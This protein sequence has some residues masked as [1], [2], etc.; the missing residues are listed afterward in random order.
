MLP[1]LFEG[2]IKGYEA[3]ATRRQIALAVQFDPT[4]PRVDGDPL[5]LERIFANLLHNASKFTPN[6]GRITVSA[7]PDQGRVAVA[8]TNTGPGIAPDEIP[9][10]FQRY[11]QTKTG[12]QKRGAGMGLFIVK[13]LAEAHGG[14]VEVE[15]TPGVETRFVVFLPVATTSPDSPTLA[16]NQRGKVTWR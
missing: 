6:G 5:A 15:S 12:R 2:L 16:A 8:V 1:V 14:S 4:L 10:L 11:Q 9:S 3:E 7:R 13:S